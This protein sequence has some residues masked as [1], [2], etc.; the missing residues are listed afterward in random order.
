M[1]AEV[2]LAESPDRWVLGNGSLEVTIDRSTGRIVG[3]VDLADGFDA[4][5]PDEPNAAMV[6]GLRITDE[7]TGETFCDLTDPSEV[8]AVE[9]G[10]GPDGSKQ[11][12]FDKQF[13]R[14]EFT[15]RVTY[16]IEADCLCWLAE[17]S[18]RRGADR[19]VR[20]VFIT[21]QP[22][23][24]L[25]GPMADP[26][27]DLQPEQPVMI[28]HG[29]GHGRAVASQKR[30]VP[31][32]LLSFIRESRCMALSLPVEVPNVLVRFMNNAD[33]AHL[34]IANSLS[35]PLVRRECFKVCYDFRAPTSRSTSPSPSPSTRAGGGSAPTA[36]AGS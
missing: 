4:C 23:R 28:R 30:A 14:A 5:R 10:P 25:W 15:V 33:E 31:V 20:I 8:A 24:R 21:P 17:V 3:L 27:I 22:S 12:A 6:G 11:V 13:D 18:K 35:Y 9:A 1:A 19:S 16:R 32:P 26:F 29:L 7:L 2:T 36:T 34:A